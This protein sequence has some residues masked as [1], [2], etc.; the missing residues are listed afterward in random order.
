[1]FLFSLSRKE[2]LHS[3]LP[4][5]SENQSDEAATMLEHG[6]WAALSRLLCG[7]H[8]FSDKPVCCGSY[9][10]NAE[11]ATAMDTMC[12]LHH[13]TPSPLPKKGR[14]HWLLWV[15]Y[16]AFEVSWLHFLVVSRVSTSS[17]L[18]VQCS[19]KQCLNCDVFKVPFTGVVML[20]LYVCDLLPCGNFSYLVPYD[21]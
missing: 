15:T 19:C 9:L 13:S 12:F 5:T 7:L 8:H 6:K 21:F 4:G 18:F 1:M 16:A 20:A 2:A 11:Q 17:S 10:C 3:C 14:G